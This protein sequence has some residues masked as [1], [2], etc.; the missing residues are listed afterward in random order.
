MNSKKSL[1]VHSV[2]NAIIYKFLEERFING[3]SSLYIGNFFRKK[4]NCTL[5]Y[6]Y[7]KGVI[8]ISE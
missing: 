8:R 6:N 4:Y 1:N 2:V 7:K 5:C 3:K